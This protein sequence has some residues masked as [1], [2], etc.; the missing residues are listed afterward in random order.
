VSLMAANNELGTL[1]P[2]AEVG[3]A[4]RERG[5]VFHSDAVQAVGRIPVDVGAWGV[6]LMSLSAHK[7]YGPKGTGALYLRRGR[8]PRLKLQPQ[9]EG[10]GQERGV[11]SG[12][13]NVPGIVGFGEASRLAAQALVS[14][15]PERLRTLRDRL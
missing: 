8:R 4:C 3:A 12:T 14:G 9:A 5:I 7:M 10:G 11:R 15:E 13:L 2:V 6:D 1:Q